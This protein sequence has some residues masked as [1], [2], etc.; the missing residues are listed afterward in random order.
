MIPIRDTPGSGNV[1]VVTYLLMGSHALIFMYQLGLGPDESRFLYLHGL[2]PAKFTVRQIAQWFTMGDSLVTFVSYMFL[3]GGLWHFI[4]NMWFLY[5]FGDNVEERLGPFRYLVFYFLCGIFSGI[6]HFV[7]NPF[8]N[9]PTIGASGAIAGVMGA[10]FLACPKA[11]ILTLI[12]IIFIPWFIEIPAFIFL[13]I[14]FVIQ[15]Y[16]AAGSGAG[17]GIAWWAHVGG[18]L[19]GMAF[20]K[21]NSRIPKVGAGRTLRKVTARKS[22]PK[23]QVVHTLADSKSYDIVG[24]IQISSLEAYAGTKKLVNIPWGFYKRLYRIK[25]PSGVKPGTRLR[26]TGMGRRMPDGKRGDLYLRVEI[27]N[28]T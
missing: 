8:S 7:L 20:L 24:D 5:I 26:L 2:V 22:T 10:Y 15:F 18:F 21:L 16:N 17:A 27:V 3:H 1:P 23:L 14:W 6:C 28:V 4:G 19:A 13:G 12:P 11:R 25:V 9:V